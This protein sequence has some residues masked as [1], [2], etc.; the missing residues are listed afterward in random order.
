MSD[1]LTRIEAIE[2]LAEKATQGPW[3]CRLNS[4]FTKGTGDFFVF[5]SYKK[6]VYKEEDGHFIAES[7]TLIPA[8]CQVVRRLIEQRDR[9]TQVSVPTEV[10]WETRQRDNAELAALLPGE[11]ADGKG[12]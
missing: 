5:I 1:I 3:T 2:E 12:E 11:D 10:L 6:G 9:W 4:T 8:L 7:R